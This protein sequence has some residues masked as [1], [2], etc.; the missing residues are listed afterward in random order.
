MVDGAQTPENMDFLNENVRASGFSICSSS[1][2]GDLQKELQQLQNRQ[3]TIIAE[4]T[5][6]VN[7]PPQ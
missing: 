1:R 5:D 6:L 2:I 7:M 4:L 3:N